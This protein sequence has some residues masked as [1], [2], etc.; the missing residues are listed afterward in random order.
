VEST[1]EAHTAASEAML[2]DSDL[3]LALWDG[4]P[5]R[6]FGGTADVVDA[7][8]RRGIEAKVIWPASA[9]RD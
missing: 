5:A 4:K 9:R 2:N 3:L 7:A 8:R 1:E 6:G